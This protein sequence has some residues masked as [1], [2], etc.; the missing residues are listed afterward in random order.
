[1]RT[2]QS[3]SA[4]AMVLVAP[5]VARAEAQRIVPVEI[6]VAGDE[7]DADRARVEGQLSDLAVD[8]RVLRGAEATRPPADGA[9]RIAFETTD[10]RS[11]RVTL[12]N[13]ATGFVQA[14]RIELPNG[15]A[16]LS[17]Q[18]ESVALTARRM[19][20]AQLEASP[21]PVPEASKVEPSPWSFGALA[22]AAGTAALEGNMVGLR[23]EIRGVARRHELRFD[24]G[25]AGVHRAFD[26]GG[27]RWSVEGLGPVA[28]VGVDR[29][30]GA[31]RLY[32]GVG[33]SFLFGSR[34]ALP[35]VGQVGAPE[36][37]RFVALPRLEVAW[38]RRVTERFALGIAIAVESELPRTTYQREGA[39]EPER[40]GA[41][42]VIEPSLALQG[43]WESEAR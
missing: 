26:D 23:G 33:A 42:P 19:V 29:A 31:S 30:W 38:S 21:A 40:I 37:S 18:R 5:A 14:R 41:S 16:A 12:T 10:D 22:G 35:G 7:D 11:R 4:L 2:L 9:L 43:A 20:K 25:L 32:A 13:T 39:A 15:P 6:L 27:Y 17:A 8:V 24:L 36:A 34:N 1:M 3:F 28:M